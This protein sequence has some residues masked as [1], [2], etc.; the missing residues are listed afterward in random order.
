MA[1][2]HGVPG[3]SSER[4]SVSVG[5]KCFAESGWLRDLAVLAGLGVALVV[6][7]VVLD[8]IGALICAWALGALTASAFFGWYIGGDVFLVPWMWGSLGEEATAGELEK[9]GSVW[10]VAHDIENSYGN[11]DHVVVG[12]G[13][14]F[15]DRHARYFSAP[16]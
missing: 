9:L 15:L 7:V 16:P 6:G 8:G 4:C 11:W 2:A 12:P 3:G 5:V 1:A 13:G 14:V 10:F